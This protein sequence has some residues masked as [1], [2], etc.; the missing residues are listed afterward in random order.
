MRSFVIAA[1]CALALTSSVVITVMQS[2][3]I[4]AHAGEIYNA[5]SPA[6]NPSDVPPWGTGPNPSASITP[7]P[8]PVVTP[9]PAPVVPLSGDKF[10]VYKADGTGPVDVSD[11]V[12]VLVDQKTGVQFL[13]YLVPTPNGL[14]AV[15]VRRN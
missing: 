9:T 1:L 7:A 4:Q 2:S 11:K 12:M 5:E 8:K 14:Q 3:I 15:M 13:V 10:L 6:W